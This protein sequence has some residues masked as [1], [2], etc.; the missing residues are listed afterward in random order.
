MSSNKSI[1]DLEMPKIQPGIYDGSVEIVYEKAI[2]RY[3]LTCNGVVWMETDGEYINTKNTM[4]A[5]YD[6]AFGDVLVTGLGFGIIALAIAQKE[7]VSS[8]T[9][10]ELSKGVIDEFQSANPANDKIKIIQA[11]ATTYIPT[12]KFDCVMPDHYELQKYDWRIKDMNRLAN[13]VDH[14]VF[15]PWSLE[16]IFLKYLYPR[17]IYKMKSE[18]LFKIHSDKMPEKWKAFIVKYFESNESLLNIEK[19]KLLNY[20]KKTAIYYYDVPEILT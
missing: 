5:Q 17:Y 12:T 8:V 13:A 4:Y 1:H 3:I 16:E 10:L 11:D 15:W 9:V 19:T 2:D 14:S 6:L 7:E 18:E 20:L